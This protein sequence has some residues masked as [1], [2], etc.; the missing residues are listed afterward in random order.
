MLLT[1]RADFYDRPLS[2]PGFGEIF[3]PAVMNVLPMTAEELESAVMGPAKR[4]P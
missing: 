1:L 2:H 4:V 3:V